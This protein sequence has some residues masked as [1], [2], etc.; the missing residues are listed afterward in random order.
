MKAATSLT[1]FSL[2]TTLFAHA[3]AGSPL[4]DLWECSTGHRL[5]QFR[6]ATDSHQSVTSIAFNHVCLFC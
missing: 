3:G 4:V 2:K 5:F 6:P 1:A